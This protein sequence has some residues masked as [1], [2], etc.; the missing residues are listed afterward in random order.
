MLIEYQLMQEYPMLKESVI[1]LKQQGIKTEPA[2]C[3]ILGL[4]GDPY[5]KLLEFGIEK[6]IIPK[7]KKMHG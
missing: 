5:E 6:G 1:E 3:E 2:F 4:E 7:R